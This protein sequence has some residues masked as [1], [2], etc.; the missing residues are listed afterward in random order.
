MQQ[1]DVAAFSRT[2]KRKPRT[3]PC[4]FCKRLDDCAFRLRKRALARNEPVSSVQKPKLSGTISH[5]QAGENRLKSLRLVISKFKLCHSLRS[6][7]YC[8]GRH[9]GR[10]QGKLAVH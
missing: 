1:M 5:H 6:D 4:L 9:S 3:K 7:S 2:V 10:A 8:H